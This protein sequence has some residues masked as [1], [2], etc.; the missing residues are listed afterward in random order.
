MYL[1]YFLFIWRFWLVN[2]FF[3]DDYFRMKLQW[4]TISPE[5]EKRFGCLRERKCLI[6]RKMEYKKCICNLL[7]ILSQDNIFNNQ[8]DELYSLWIFFTTTIQF[9]IK[10]IYWI[11][12]PVLYVSYIMLLQNV[13]YQNAQ[14]I[15]YCIV[16]TKLFDYIMAYSNNT[17]GIL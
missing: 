8:I 4:K 17:S 11:N 7:D 16:N 15:M 2:S 13:W 3:R 12:W 1:Y 10:T 9:Y 5:Q 14:Y 6:G